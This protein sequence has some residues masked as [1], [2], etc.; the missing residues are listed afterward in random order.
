M[1]REMLNE[2]EVAKILSLSV[3]TLRAW[4]AKGD[5]GPRFVR[6]SNRCRYPARDLAAYVRGLPT[7]GGAVPAGGG[8]ATAKE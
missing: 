7:G 6:I 5:R 8:E 2:T 4:R 3:W 1:E